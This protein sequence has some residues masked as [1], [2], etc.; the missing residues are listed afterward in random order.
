[1]F[2]LALKGNTYKTHLLCAD[3]IRIVDPY[4]GLHREAPPDHK[5]EVGRRCGEECEEVHSGA[6]AEYQSYITLGS[7][8]IMPERE[9]EW[10]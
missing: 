7:H 4:Y 6:F 2:A 9:V 10:S 5:K 8:V 1:M 3:L